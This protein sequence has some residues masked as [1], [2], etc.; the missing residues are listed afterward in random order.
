MNGMRRM[1]RD[2]GCG[3][4]KA[5]EIKVVP[6]V[7]IEPDGGDIRGRWRVLCYICVERKIL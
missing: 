1:R 4:M 3:E 5:K 6:V 7:V 2:L